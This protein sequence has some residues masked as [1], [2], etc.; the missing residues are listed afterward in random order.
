M[1][2]YLIT[3]LHNYLIKMKISTVKKGTETFSVSPVI[4]DDAVVILVDHENKVVS[5]FRISVAEVE[6]YV[7]D[8][9]EKLAKVA[10][11][12]LCLKQAVQ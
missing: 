6:V 11:S 5:H 4:D 1:P 7:V 2:Y 8:A 9:N 10:S 3:P 12:G